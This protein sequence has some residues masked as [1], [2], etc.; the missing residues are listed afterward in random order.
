VATPD[1][2]VEEVISFQEFGARAFGNDLA[3]AHDIGAIGDV[4][5]AGGVLLDDEQGAA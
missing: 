1:E 2:G 4:E 5:H 3:A